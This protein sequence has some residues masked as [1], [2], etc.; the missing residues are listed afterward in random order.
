MQAV[1][2]RRKGVQITSPKLPAHTGQDGGGGDNGKATP[3]R[4]IS[5]RHAEKETCMRASLE[6]CT[7]IEDLNIAGLTLLQTR[8]GDGELKEGPSVKRTA[9]RHR[10]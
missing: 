5:H 4:G 3:N 2:L 6:P 10:L 7:I 8:L 1:F 9:M